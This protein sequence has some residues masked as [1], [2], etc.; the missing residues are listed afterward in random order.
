[1]ALRTSGSTFGQ[2]ERAAVRSATSLPPE[3]YFSV[4]PENLL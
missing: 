2:D 3:S 1:M 4:C